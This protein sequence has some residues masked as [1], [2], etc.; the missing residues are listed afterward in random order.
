MT[1]IS[2]IPP[3]RPLSSGCN[4]LPRTSKAVLPS[5]FTS[6]NNDNSLMYDQAVIQKESS[7]MFTPLTRSQLE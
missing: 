4:L 6:H 3:C 7:L 2:P 1:I 5:L